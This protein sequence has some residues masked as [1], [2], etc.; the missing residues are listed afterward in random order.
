M[1]STYYSEKKFIFQMMTS[2][3]YFYSFICTTTHKLLS[4][5]TY[6][7]YSLRT[8][9]HSGSKQSTPITTISNS[10]ESSFYVSSSKCVVFTIHHYH[11]Y[12]CY[13]YPGRPVRIRIVSQFCVTCCYGL[14]DIYYLGYCT[15]IYTTII[16]KKPSIYSRGE[17]GVLRANV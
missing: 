14:Q 3:E 5:L 2:F 11:C 16:K 15:H 17:K 9:Q 1:M 12:G 4:I 13:E 10:I 8:I 6:Y 7:S